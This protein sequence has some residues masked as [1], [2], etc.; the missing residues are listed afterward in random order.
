MPVVL[1]ILIM[2]LML[3]VLTIVHEWGHFICARIFKVKVVEFSIFMGP[4][5]FQ[6]TSKKT[7]TKFTLRAIPLGGYCAFEDDQGDANAP[8]SLYAQ[9]WYK[10]AIIFAGGVTMNFLLAWLITT[11]IVGSGYFTTTRLEKVSEDSI[12][13]FVGIREGDSLVKFDDLLTST[14]T[15]VT[16]AGYGIEDLDKS[17]EVMHSHY[18]LTYRRDGSDIKYDISKIINYKI[19]TKAVDGTETEGLEIDDYSYTVIRTENG[20]STEYVY[21]AK[22]NSFSEER[23]KAFCTVTKTVDGVK[24]Y[25]G[26]EAVT[27]ENYCTLANSGF[28]VV[29]TWNPFELIGHAFLEMISMIKSVYVSLWWIITGKIGLNG[30]AGPIG[31]TSV[32]SDVVGAEAG[33]SLKIITLVNM[34]AL[35]S[36]NLGVVNALPIPGLD[37]SHL[38]LILIEVITGGKKLPPKTQAIISYVG[39][40]L[41]IL[42]AV[43]VAGNDIYKLIAGG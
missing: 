6:K 17:D 12:A 37:G 19:V 15:D 2:I 3:S 25:E 31:L 34:A 4:K 8:D 11:F 43:F 30:L 22:I 29:S 23:D 1:S 38:L 33:V 14:G 7:G 27:A 20:R 41:M 9:K 42:L 24:E 5:L 32:V 36:A 40:G 26:E 21:T 13:Y 28:H 10:R 18:V 16:L 39:L 35:I